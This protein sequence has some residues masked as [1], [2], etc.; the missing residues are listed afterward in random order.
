MTKSTRSCPKCL[1]SKQVMGMGMIYRSCEYCD[2]VGYVFD[3]SALEKKQPKSSNE[4][5][6]KKR[7]R[8][9]RQNS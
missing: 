2:G 6:V 7:G 9:A 1:C 3:D 4:E 8:P 5:I